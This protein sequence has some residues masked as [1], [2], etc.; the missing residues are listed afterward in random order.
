[1]RNL[2]LAAA[3]LLAVAAQ[4][5]VFGPVLG[6]VTPTS[7]QIAWR[8]DGEVTGV[9]L[10]G[11][12]QPEKVTGKFHLVSLTGLKADTTYSYAFVVDKK[13]TAYTFRT[14]PAKAVDFTFGVYGDSRW[15]TAV[16]KQIVAAYG[17]LQPRFILNSGDVVSKGSDEGDWEAFFAVTLPLTA[18][19][20][21]CVAPG[22]HEGN[23]DEVFHLFP[24]GTEG[25]GAEGRE[26]STFTYGNVRVVLLNSTRNLDE[27]TKWLDGVLAK[28]TST[29]TVVAFHH[30]P[31]SSGD[32]NG[33]KDIRDKWVPVLE[34]YKV[35]AVF[36]GHDHFYEHSQKAGVHYFI[37]G[38]GGAALYAPGRTTN[39]HLVKNEKVNHYLTV[40]V[41]ART[42]RIRMLHLDGTVGEEVV[43][44]K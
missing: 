40:D 34:K 31:Y 5:A 38:G 14:A 11:T 6:R 15:G 9:R 2:Y 7:V 22:N 20:P 35:H 39:P 17:K 13:A 25:G 10:N 42:L 36:L 24:G 19:I 33:S 12:L 16:H 28:N 27:Q 23:V 18:R 1:M 30:P 32:R 21:Y 43:V 3:L 41:T 26:W 44:T 4:A 8:A 29:W 37:T